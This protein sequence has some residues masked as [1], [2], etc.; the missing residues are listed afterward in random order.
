MLH[1]IGTFYKVSNLGLYWSFFKILDHHVGYSGQMAHV[2]SPGATFS[3]DIY[4]YTLKIL[5]NHRVPFNFMMTIV[6]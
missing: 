4:K 3:P 6:P 1:S 2:A 5:L